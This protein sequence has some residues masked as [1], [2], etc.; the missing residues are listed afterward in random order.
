MVS[1]SVLAGALVCMMLGQPGQELA[2]QSAPQQPAPGWAEAAAIPDAPK[3]QALP[4]EPV[5][6]GRGT[7]P[8]SNGDGSSTSE[9]DA[10]PNKLPETA[11]QKADDGQ[12]A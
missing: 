11:A 8:D 7:T 12:A 4:V 5:T 10:V 2:Q 3:P 1:K 6:P 9:E